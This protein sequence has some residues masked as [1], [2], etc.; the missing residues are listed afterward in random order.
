MSHMMSSRRKPHERRAF[1]WRMRRR[2]RQKKKIP[3]CRHDA[4]AAAHCR[5]KA[6]RYYSRDI[7]S[8]SQACDDVPRNGQLIS[9]ALEECR[10]VEYMRHTIHTRYTSA[11]GRQLY[12]QKAH[13]LRHDA[14]RHARRQD[15]HYT[16]LYFQV[17]RRRFTPLY[18]MF[19]LL[20]RYARAIFYR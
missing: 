10:S 9:L 16:M 19:S 7:E 15:Y 13:V 6:S 5:K 18:S 14:R 20:R 17:P 2:P 11:S 12:T 8:R 4:A 3:A 1:E